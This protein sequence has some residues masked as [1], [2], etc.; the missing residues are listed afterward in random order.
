V[1]GRNAK[2]PSENLIAQSNA[3]IG[4]N[5]IEKKQDLFISRIRAVPPGCAQDS[6][7]ILARQ[8]GLLKWMLNE[9]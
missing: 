4:T 2:Y 8:S 9:F 5:Q 3:A 7:D 1:V 6:T